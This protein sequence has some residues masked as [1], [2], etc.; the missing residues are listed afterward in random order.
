MKLI[1]KILKISTKRFIPNLFKKNT[2]NNNLSF[3][4]QKD[5]SLKKLINL[6][7]YILSKKLKKN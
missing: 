4:Q 2:M 3:Q 6:F 1:K 5:Y 7:F